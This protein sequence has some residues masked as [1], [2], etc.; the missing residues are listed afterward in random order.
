MVLATIVM[1][2]RRLFR[3]TLRQARTSTFTGPPLDQPPELGISG[4]GTVGMGPLGVA[5]IWL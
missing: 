5:P 4:G 1:R 2:E 3:Q